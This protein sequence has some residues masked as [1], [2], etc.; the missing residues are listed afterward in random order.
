MEN[1]ILKVPAEIKYLPKIRNYIEYRALQKNYSEK[2]IHAV[3]LATEEV[4]TNVIRHGYKDIKNGTIQIEVIS[5]RNSLT[6]NIIDQGQ[7]YDPKQ[8]KDPDL[9]EY[10]LS[11]KMGGLGIMMIRKLM[12]EIRYK[13]TPRGNEL[14]LTKYR[15]QISDSRF[16]KLWLFFEKTFKSQFLAYGSLIFFFG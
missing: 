6:V 12:D 13:V 14:Q 7:T 5:K 16:S 3:K 4:C 11:G 15:Q 10:V 9:N 2:I 8:V 1:S